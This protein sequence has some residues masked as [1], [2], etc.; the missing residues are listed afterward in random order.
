MEAKNSD[1]VSSSSATKRKLA[2][3]KQKDSKYE[4]DDLRRMISQ[5][6]VAGALRSAVDDVIIRTGIEEKSDHK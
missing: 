2:E 3:A 6:L 1:D 5:K 4:E